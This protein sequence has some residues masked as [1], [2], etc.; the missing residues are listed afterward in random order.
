MLHDEIILPL[1]QPV[2][3]ESGEML[4]R[5][6]DA[7]VIRFPPGGTCFPRRG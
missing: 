4:E 6:D 7:V 1:K 3:V 5:T 2:S